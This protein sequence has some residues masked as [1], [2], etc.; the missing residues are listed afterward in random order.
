MACATSP[1]W[2][3]SG[4]SCSSTVLTTARL[5]EAR[6]TSAATCSLFFRVLSSEVVPRVKVGEGPAI[7]APLRQAKWGGMSIDSI[8][9]I[10]PPDAALLRIG[11]SCCVA[12]G[13]SRSPTESAASFGLGRWGIFAAPGKMQNIL[14]PLQGSP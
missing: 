4:S 14:F 2:T 3:S 9:R 12:T 6:C 7:E 10:V 5:S 8:P 11:N 1:T 13:V